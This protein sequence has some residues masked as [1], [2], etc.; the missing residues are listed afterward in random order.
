MQ[1]P[2]L[3]N[4]QLPASFL[5][6]LLTDLSVHGDMIPEDTVLEVERAVRNDWIGSRLCRDATDEE[7][8]EY[9]LEQGAAELISD[10]IQALAKDKG[11]LE[12][13]VADL[14][15]QHGQLT[16]QVKQLQADVDGLA[17]QKKKLADEVAALE[18]AKKAAG[19]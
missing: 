17:E 19:K 7:I 15:L 4:P 14:K 13:G 9:R 12:D 8:A 18:K 6:V 2:Q 16:D 5:V 10:D 1:T 11:D 3:Y